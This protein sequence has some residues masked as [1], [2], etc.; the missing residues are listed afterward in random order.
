M[1]ELKCEAAYE[2]NLL[3][4]FLYQIICNLSY[5]RAQNSF[6]NESYCVNK[7]NFAQNLMNFVAD[8]IVFAIVWGFFSLLIKFLIGLNCASLCFGNDV[9]HAWKTQRRPPLANVKK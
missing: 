7:S 3:Q 2:N 6:P 4:D 1:I 8:A 9:E 5:L